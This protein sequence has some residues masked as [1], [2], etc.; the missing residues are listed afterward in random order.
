METLRL[1][2]VCKTYKAKKRKEQDVEAVKNF[3]LTADDD[4]FIVFVGPSGCG[5]STTLRRIAGFEE[6]TS[7]DLYINGQRR[8]DIEPNYRDIAMVFQN[9]ALYPHR[10]AYQNRAFGLKNRHVP[11]EEIDKRIHA[12]AKI[13]DIEE[14]LNRKP[15]ARSGGQRQRVALGRAIVRRPKIFLLDEPLSNLDAKLRATRRVEITR[16]FEKLK[17]TFIYVTHDQVEARTMGSRIV[18][19]NKGVVQQ[20]DTPT[21]IFDY[22]KNR[23]VA[24]F[25]GTPQRNFY[26]GRGQKKENNFV[27]STHGKELSFPLSQLKE[28]NQKVLD[29]KAHKRILGIRPDDIKVSADG[30][31]KTKVNILEVLGNET[32]LYTDLDL[33]KEDASNTESETSL[34]IKVPGRVDARKDDIVSIRIPS[35]KIHFF[36]DDEK[37]EKSLFISPRS[38]LFERKGYLKEENGEYY[39]LLE[40]G[41]KLSLDFL[42]KEELH[43]V[44]QSGTH[45][46]KRGLNPDSVSFQEDGEIEAIYEGDGIYRTKRLSRLELNLNLDY[47]E[48]FD[49]PVS[50]LYVPYKEG[51]KIGDKVRI[52]IDTSTLDFIGDDHLSVHDKKEKTKDIS[53]YKISER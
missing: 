41:R 33:E 17:T 19:R 36:E 46:V 16:L 21:N 15:G 53:E 35:E 45:R 48:S 42:K 23:F 50:H 43:P 9:Y 39:F 26:E 31:L 11:K 8:N 18:V 29:G 14:L 22:P 27:F 28:L 25:L 7:G 24:G 34:V 49:S 47:D 2:N 44:Y 5:K 32:I 6:I 37:Y 40:N 1:E 51:Y 12:A 38:S 30:Q 4:E 52:H 10:T 20:V 13:L 3:S